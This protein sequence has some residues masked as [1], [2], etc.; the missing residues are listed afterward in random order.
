MTPSPATTYPDWKAPAED[1]QTLL[2]PE[3]ADILAQARENHR[4][5]SGASHVTLQNVP[6]PELR[7]RMRE[8]IGHD[9]ARPLIAS[10]HQTELCHAGVWAK[11]ALG[12]A[13]ARKLDGA[14]Y[15]LA[16]ETDA[17]KHLHLK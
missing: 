13:V 2:W 8:W 12:N 14:A 10:G 4:R 16:I 9:D 15:H 7:K 3:P 17:P 5:L 6:L 11:D 1:G